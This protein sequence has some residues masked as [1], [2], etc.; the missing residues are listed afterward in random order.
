[1]EKEALHKDQK[2]ISVITLIAH[3]D[4]SWKKGAMLLQEYG[5]PK[6]KGHI[7]LEEKLTDLYNGASKEKQ[8]ELKKKIAK[9]HPHAEFILKHI[10]KNGTRTYEYNDHTGLEETSGCDGC[11]GSCGAK[12]EA[13]SGCDGCKNYSHFMPQSFDDMYSLATGK[14]SKSSEDTTPAEAPKKSLAVPIIVG[15]SVVLVS[16]IA[17]IVILK[18]KKHKN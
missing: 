16:L 10:S 17:G 1:M 7:D 8:E 13:I 11:K 14:K 5:W 4:D 6:A 2:D 18:L 15:T 9:I 12:K 3:D